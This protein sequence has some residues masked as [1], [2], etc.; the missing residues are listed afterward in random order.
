L[1]LKKIK[2]RKNFNS[3]KIALIAAI[4]TISMFD[5]WFWSLHFGVLFFWMIIGLMLREE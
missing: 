2:E 5:H 1:L 4:I 3:Y